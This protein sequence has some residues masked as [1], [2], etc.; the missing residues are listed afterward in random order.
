LG[1][2]RAVVTGAG[3]GIGRSI[4]LRLA[5]EGASVAVADV[6]GPAAEAV[7]AEILAEDGNAIALQCDV[8]DPA[9]VS[10]TMVRASDA[11]DGIDTLVACAGIA[12]PA[13]THQ[14]EIDE[15][16]A[17][18]RVNLTGVFLAV[19]HALPHMLAANSGAIV[20]IGSIA[21]LVAAGN[22]SA[23]EASKGGVLMFTRAVAAEYAEQGIRANCICPGLIQ[24]DLGKNTR[25]LLGDSPAEGRPLIAERVQ[26]PIAGRSSP[27]AIAAAA[28]YLCSDDASFI[29]GIALPVDGGYTA[30]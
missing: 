2:R 11:L 15:W 23:Y 9:D 25:T 12:F 13:H 19:R 8:G 14:T 16:D 28:A 17:I 27:E 5:R 1:G 10:S 18:V 26:V 29:T 3:S 22:N 20:T 7:C 30:I 24:T 6:R 4:A 21:S